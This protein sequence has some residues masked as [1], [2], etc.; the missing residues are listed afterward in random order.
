[1][2]SVTPAA[3][4]PMTEAPDY[5]EDFQSFL[6]RCP[7]EGGV[8]TVLSSHIVWF[9]SMPLTCP[10]CHHPLDTTNAGLKSFYFILF[11]FLL[12][13][14]IESI[15]WRVS[16]QS[17]VVAKNKMVSP[18]VQSKECWDYSC[19][20]QYLFCLFFKRVSGIKFWSSGLCPLSH[21]PGPWSYI[22]DI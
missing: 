14:G 5:S 20:P 11:Y 9:S 1:M 12:L 18:E 17:L 15:C 4:D 2:V 16:V 10:P 7:G 22:L 13:L 19:K 21:F 6:T 8:E 3:R